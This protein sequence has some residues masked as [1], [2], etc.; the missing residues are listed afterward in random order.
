FVPC[1]VDGSE[2][3]AKIV[4]LS[5]LPEL[6]EEA[7]LPPAPPEETMQAALPARILISD[8]ALDLPVQNPE[9]RDIAALDELLKKGPI[10]YVDSAKLGEDG[11]VLIFAHTSHLPVVKNQMYKAFNRIPEL[12]PGD[13]ITLDGED[14][15]GVKKTYL[16]TVNSVRQV[17]AKDASVDLSAGLGKKLTLVTC[18]TLTGKTARFLLEA[19]FVA[20][21]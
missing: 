6:G 11:N 16:Y 2:C 4:P 13:L 17:D 14:Q 3:P 18:D 21:F 9:T 1:Y 10:R 7:A 5:T 8:V 20:S 19:D 15:N 12:K